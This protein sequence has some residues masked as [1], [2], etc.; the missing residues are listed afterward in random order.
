[1]ILLEDSC[2]VCSFGKACGPANYFLRRHTLLSESCGIFLF[3]K[4]KFR[5]SGIIV[6]INAYINLV[7]EKMA[8]IFH[9]S[10]KP[11]E[12]KRV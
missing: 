12:S 4:R 7:A 6:W 2:V 11:C 8:A 5:Y 1:M 9:L 10:L 3:Q